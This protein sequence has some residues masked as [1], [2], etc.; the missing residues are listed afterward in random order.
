MAKST[1]SRQK[2][3]V[4]GRPNA[5]PT[6]PRHLFLPRP[7]RRVVRAPAC[8]VLLRSTHTLRLNATAPDQTPAGAARRERN[9]NGQTTPRPECG[10]LIGAHRPCKE[11][12]WRLATCWHTTERQRERAQR[13]WRPQCFVLTMATTGAST[14]LLAFIPGCSPLPGLACRLSAR[15]RVDLPS[16]TVARGWTVF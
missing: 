6:S 15:R 11:T 10:V 7:P 12:P 5:R 2:D 14:E 3:T 1:T 9:I 16:H 13:C 4:H 8:G